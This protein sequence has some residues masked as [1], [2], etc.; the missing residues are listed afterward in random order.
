MF[1]TGSQ[2]QE[3]LKIRENGDDFFVQFSGARPD[4][5]RLSGPTPAEAVRRQ[6][7]GSRGAYLDSDSAMP[8]LTTDTL[9]RR[10]PR[11]HKRLSDQREES[12]SLLM[13]E[14]NKVQR[15]KYRN[16]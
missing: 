1:Q 16:T 12:I 10:C 15:R 6:V 3:V 5:G 13:R 4:T 8:I 7:A 2:I 11:K 9:A 14:Y